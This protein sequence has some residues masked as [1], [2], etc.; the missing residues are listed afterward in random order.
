MDGDGEPI[1]PRGGGLSASA[2]WRL[3]RSGSWNTRTLVGRNRPTW[4]DLFYPKILSVLGRGYWRQ[5]LAGDLMAGTIVGIV[6][7]PLAIA[8]A[9]ASGRRPEAGLI[10]A[11]AAGFLI[12]LLGG[13]RVQIGGPTGAF[14][15]IIAD[16]A[17][18][19]GPAGLAVST[20]L[21]GLFLVG[22]GLLRL[23]GVIKL[24]PHPVIAGFTA[25]IAVVIFSGQIKDALG[26]SPERLPGEWGA[27]PG[28]VL[29][30]SATVGVILAGRKLF[31]RI[32]GSLIAILLTTAATAIFGLPVETIGDRFGDLPIGLG[33]I[34]AGVDLFSLPNYFRPAFTIALLCAIESLLSAVVADG[35]IGD[36]HHSNTE[37]IA[38]GIANL[39]VPLFGGIPATGAIAR[40]VT[41]VKSG[42][43]TPV[44]GIA[45]AAV[46]FLITVFLGGY[47]RL[48]P[49]SCLAG[50][51]MVVAYNMGE[52]RAFLSLLRAPVHES[53]VL[54]TT[55]L[56]TVLVDL[57]VA[58]EI[59]MLLASFIFIQRMSEMGT[60]FS[61]TLRESGDPGEP[62]DAP[63]RSARDK[64]NLVDI[65]EISG[66]FFFAAAREYQQAIQS[67]GTGA[68][69]VLIRMRHV[70]FA[71]E[72]GIRVF[73]DALR[74]MLASRRVV[75]LS[76]VR[77]NVRDDFRRHGIIDL[78]GED[79]IFDNFED[80][81]KF[82]DP[83]Y[84]RTP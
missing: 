71:D 30:A 29:T 37:L 5:G 45:H 14:V 25:G 21:A 81:M 38:Q 76:G 54:L 55:F 41:N 7:L 63:F 16:I 42:G 64:R 58:I 15:V 39:A 82:L 6:A 11:V 66:P 31:P 44:A 1:R 26:L 73:R 36:R 35:M 40:T 47:A 43:I 65:F 80:A 48:I 34:P 4:R 60:V 46:L 61:T 10:T 77:E 72:T 28:S 52:W 67:L 12:S 9:V 8:F 84:E 13:S 33:P 22:F 3:R 51:L 20:M 69:S 59:G 74:A 19:Y 75:V 68:R 32:P 23:G 78:L 2:R 27:R 53:A 62:G 24:I 49:L 56:L 83:D 17:S 70:P 50:I 79:R 18:E 57:T